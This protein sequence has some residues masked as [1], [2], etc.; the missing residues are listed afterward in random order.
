VYKVSL[1]QRALPVWSAQMSKKKK[2]A[3]DTKIPGIRFVTGSDCGYRLAIQVDSVQEWDN[4]L[5][6]EAVGLIAE[7]NQRL[8][9]A[10]TEFASVGD[11]E[12]TDLILDCVNKMSLQLAK[13]Y[14]VPL[15]RFQL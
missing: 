6:K 11:W 8:A 14:G 5:V 15:E 2:P 4:I 12:M 7:S 10:A 9:T 13:S 1:A 3:Q